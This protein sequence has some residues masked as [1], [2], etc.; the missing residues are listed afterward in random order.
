M[1]H[2]CLELLDLENS[3]PH[4]ACTLWN[5]SNALEGQL[6][7]ARR[8]LAQGGNPAQAEKTLRTYRLYLAG[9]AMSF[10]QGWISLCQLLAAKPTG[11]VRDSNENGGP[12]LRGAQSSYRFNRGCMCR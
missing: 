4:Y 2:A 6:G 12:V 5:W 10:A 1:A 8:L 9:S 7:D 3:R 11:H